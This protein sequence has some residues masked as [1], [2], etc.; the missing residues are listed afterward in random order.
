MAA[1]QLTGIILSGGK[2]SRMGREKG[3][4]NFRGKPLVSYAISSLEPVADTLIIS[5]NEQLKEYRRFGLAV[6]TDEIKGI[7]PMGGLHTA[8]KY[9]ETEHNLVLSCDMPFVSAG[10]MDYLYQ[11]VQDYDIVVAMHGKDRLEPLCGYY[12]RRVI[13]VLEEKIKELFEE[14]AGKKGKR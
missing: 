3:L 6:V 11:N 13:G 2:S 5:I 14:L 4:V 7:G 12:A 1:E 8:L 10:L 9:S